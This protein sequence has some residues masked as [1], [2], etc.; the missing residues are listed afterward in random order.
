MFPTEPRVA[1]T[2]GGVAPEKDVMPAEGVPAP[3][4]K[5][6]PQPEPVD[7]P[8]QPVDAE[9]EWKTAIAAETAKVE[10]KYKRD[11]ARLQSTLD[12]RRA[13][14]VGQRE[15][16]I[17]ALRRQQEAELMSRMTD[18]ERTAYERE[19]LNER[20]AT[21]QEQLE[22][23]RQAR[24]AAMQM[25]QYHNRLSSLGV[26]MDGLDFS[27]PEG[28]F[29][30]ADEKF[31]D[32]IRD[33]QAKATQRPTQ[34]APEAPPV[35]PSPV[36]GRPRPPQV[37]TTTGTPAPSLTP[38]QAFDQLRKLQSERAGRQLSEE[39]VWRMIETGQ[40]DLNQTIPGLSE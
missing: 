5:P 13:A 39:E 25:L 33:L 1:G 9:A 21:L 6:A 35:T 24:S 34:P 17:E 14:E 19:V 40:I 28:F 10:A 3:A 20:T 22:Q 30:A 12:A 36:P 2:T 29:R 15:R 23:E 38:N 4:P 31:E 26:P 32:Y 7:A 18:E 27:D 16:E 11:M 8:E 37:V